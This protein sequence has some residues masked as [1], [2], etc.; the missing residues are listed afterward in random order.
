[1]MFFDVICERKRFTTHLPGVF[2]LLRE[3]RVAAGNGLGTG[4][5]TSLV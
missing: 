4:L 5:G 1:M 2:I 3:R